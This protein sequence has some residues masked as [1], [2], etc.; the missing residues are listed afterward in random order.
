VDGTIR[1]L[2]NVMGLWLVDECRRA[3]SG[4]RLQELL[5][6]ARTA[7]ADIA[8]F[9]PD[10]GSLLAPGTDM[11]ERISTL[12]TAAGQAAP[13]GRG[14]LIRSVLVS[15]ACKYRLVLEQLEGVVERRLEPI[16]VV[17]GG[18]QNELLC[19]LTADLCQ[20]EVLAGPVEATAMGNVLLQA[21]ALG[22]LAG[23][24]ELRELARRSTSLRRFEPA[25]PEWAQ[26]TFQRFLEVTGAAA[27][28]S[29]R[30]TA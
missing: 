21:M 13:E 27:S 29:L 17:G 8:L 4:M 15:L 25:E 3:W 18:A 26:A 19:E 9:E 12:C 30:T 2:R 10:D 28:Q 23:L 14:E 24:R 11:P 5:D 22:E 7:P 1:L 6:L 20:R 16:H